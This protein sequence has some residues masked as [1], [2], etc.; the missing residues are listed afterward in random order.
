MKKQGDHM[1]LTHLYCRQQ[2]TMYWSDLEIMVKKLSFGWRPKRKILS[3]GHWPPVFSHTYI[4]IQLCCIHGRFH[5]FFI[6]V[7]LGYIHYYWYYTFQKNLLQWVSCICLIFMV[8]KLDGDVFLYGTS[9]M[10]FFMWKF[11]W[12]ATLIPVS[13]EVEKS[14]FDILKLEIMNTGPWNYLLHI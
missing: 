6:N 3:Y 7:V 13:I 9:L 2:N 5:I 8:S 12:N 10:T 14:Y 4:K 11:P 1:I